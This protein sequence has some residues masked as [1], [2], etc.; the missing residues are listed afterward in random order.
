VLNHPDVQ[1]EL[2]AIR[3]VR[4]DAMAETP[5]TDL[6]GKKTTPRAWAAALKLNH[7]PGMV[8]FDDGK[9][10][11]RMEGRFYKFHFKEVLRYVSSGAYKRYDR[12]GAYLDD[13]QQELLSKGVNIDFSE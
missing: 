6:Q 13:R 7:R 11:V 9:E 4:L 5:I 1:P 2:K 12:F 10:V 8:L 3:V